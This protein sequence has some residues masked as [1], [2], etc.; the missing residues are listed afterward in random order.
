VDEWQ[1]ADFFVALI[2][3]ASRRTVQGET[4]HDPRSTMSTTATGTIKIFCRAKEKADSYEAE[5][6]PDV[7]VAEIITGLEE[8]DYLPALAAGERWRVV[9]GR[10]RTDLPPSVR[11]DEQGVKDGDQLDFVRDSH[12]AWA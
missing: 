9:L 10:T 5:V 3:A 1:R 4:G 12:G 7:T 11:L 6:V 8:D 2:L